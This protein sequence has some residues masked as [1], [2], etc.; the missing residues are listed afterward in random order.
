M[1]KML[2]VAVMALGAFNVSAQ[3]IGYIS[4]DELIGSMP[5]ADKADKELQVYQE[6]LGKQGQDMMKELS[7]KDSLFVK[8]SAK[9]SPTMKDLKRR[10]LIELYQKVQGWQ[11][12]AQELYNVEAQKKIAPIRTKALDAIKTVAKENGYAY[13]MDVQSV[14]V[15]PPGDDLLP[16]VK[17]KLGIKDTPAPAGGTPRN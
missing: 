1:K 10:E 16:L 4:P 12:Q 17:K 2:V 8:D 7:V 5:E 15:A 13:V 6:E 9:L 14:I 3:K 11:N